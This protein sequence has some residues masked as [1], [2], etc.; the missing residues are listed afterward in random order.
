MKI[1][2][3]RH[4]PEFKR[5]K[6]EYSEKTMFYPPVDLILK[7]DKP[8]FWDAGCGHGE[9]IKEMAKNNPQN[10]YFAT[11]IKRSRAE[12][13]RFLLNENNCENAFVFRHESSLLIKDLPDNCL[14]G[15]FINHPDPWPK[16]RHQKNRLID[17]EFT[18]N[19]I[20]VLKKG[21]ILEYVTDF[22]QY[23]KE[24]LKI[25]ESF[26]ELEKMW[27][28]GDFAQPYKGRPTTSY[29]IKARAKG[30]PICFLFFRKKRFS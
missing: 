10:I 6:S 2:R 29:E 7:K 27:K 19:L 17:L 5:K 20:R 12:E 24:T 25:F 9:F 16:N 18:K 23:G 13:T 11:E 21:G 28:S 30:L 1:L 22:A 8:T 3:H 4:N 26:R 14:D 15:I